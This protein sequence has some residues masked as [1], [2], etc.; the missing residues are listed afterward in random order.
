[1]PRQCLRQLDTRQ[2]GLNTGALGAHPDQLQ[3]ADSTWGLLHERSEKLVY[4]F[5]IAPTLHLGAH[6]AY[7]V[8][9]ETNMANHI[10]GTV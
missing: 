4:E 3:L 7:R 1:M 9:S 2:S 5:S 10:R 8:G 6:T